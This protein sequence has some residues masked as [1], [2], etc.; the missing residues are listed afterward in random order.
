MGG[1]SHS[2]NRAIVEAALSVALGKDETKFLPSSA[3]SWQNEYDF[4]LQN[5]KFERNES[6]GAGNRWG[7]NEQVSFSNESRGTGAIGA[8]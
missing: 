7:V 6:R 3:A 1:A 5:R 4:G 8:G 2:K